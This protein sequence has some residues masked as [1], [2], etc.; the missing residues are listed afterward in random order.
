MNLYTNNN[1]PIGSHLVSAILRHD[2]VP[3]PVSLECVIQADGELMSYLMVGQTLHL[4][5]GMSLTIVQSRQETNPVIKDAKMMNHVFITAVLSSLACLLDN[6]RR[7]LVLHATSIGQIYRSLGA[8]VSFGSD[9]AVKDFVCLA[10][11][12]PT[13]RIA[14]ALQ[15]EAGVVRYKD[16]KL[17]ALSIDGLFRQEAHTLVDTSVLWFDNNQ[18]NT[19]TPNYYSIDEHDG[20][21]LGQG[22][23]GTVGYL[24]G[25]DERQLNNLKKVLVC[26]GV[27]S[28]AVVNIPAG[29]VV[30]VGGK[31]YIVLTSAIRIDT[32]SVG[33]TPATLGKLW[34]AT[35]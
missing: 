2:L 17:H 22:M 8:D 6:T 10:G 7:A 11:Q 21:E 19:Q 33:G 30:D 18:N 4:E 27:L 29:D 34:L 20:K 1:T 14:V 23:G 25:C 32:A 26:R 24:P 16:G 3:I 9:I 12:M 15:K 31:K 5:N 13:N 35:L 28:R